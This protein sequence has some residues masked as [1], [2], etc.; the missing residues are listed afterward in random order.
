MLGR[1]IERVGQ[2]LLALGSIFGRF[3]L[4]EARAEVLYG[5]RR[6]EAWKEQ[7]D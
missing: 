6:A 1:L 4:L 5:R 7:S 2:P 3:G